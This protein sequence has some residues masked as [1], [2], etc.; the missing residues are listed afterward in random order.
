MDSL[1]AQ[2]LLIHLADG[3]I[4]PPDLWR[5][6]RGGALSCAY[7]AGQTT[8]TWRREEVAELAGRWR[9]LDNGRLPERVRCFREAHERLEALARDNGLTAPDMMIWDVAG[10]EL[11]AVWEDAQV[12]LVV[13]EVGESAS[14]GTAT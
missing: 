8:F 5:H 14:T 7:E 2:C 3:E 11:R 10:A 13:A 1:D 4:P 6:D 12:V 9:D